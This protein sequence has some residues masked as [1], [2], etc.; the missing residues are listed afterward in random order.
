MPYSSEV[1]RAL[2]LEAPVVEQRSCRR[3]RRARCWCCRRRWRAA[4][5]YAPQASVEPL[6]GGRAAGPA[7]HPRRAPARAPSSRA[8]QQRA[9]RCRCPRPRPAAPRRSVFTSTSWPS[10]EDSA[11]HALADRLE[12]LLA[13]A[14]PA[15]ARAGS[16]K[17]GGEERRGSPAAPRTGP[18]RWPARR[19][20]G[21]KSSRRGV[22]VHADAEHHEVHPVRLG[23]Q[24]GEDAG[25]LLARQPGRRW[26]T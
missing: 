6:R 25:D 14:G 16:S 1:R 7:P 10:V 21:G 9:R 12:A 8:D 3:R 15:T 11:F 2:G 26:A 22:Q 17:R 23:G 20:S 5:A 4:S 18:A 19:T 13:G 24:L